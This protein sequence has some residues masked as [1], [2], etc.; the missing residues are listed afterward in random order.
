M[1]RDPT[2]ELNQWSEISGGGRRS[3]RD[4]W[5]SRTSSEVLEKRNEEIFWVSIVFLI[6]P[7]EFQMVGNM[8]STWWVGFH[9]NP[10]NGKIN[11]V[12][13]VFLGIKKVKTN[14]KQGNV[15]DSHSHGPQTPI[16]NSPL[17]V[18]LGMQI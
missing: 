5:L 15:S 17:V 2:V 7:K 3:E 4:Q 12:G 10:M 9:F 13:F 6:V 14:N 1:E 18:N 16:P 11:E 8:K